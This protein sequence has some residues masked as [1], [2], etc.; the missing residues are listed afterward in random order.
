MDRVHP[1]WK[2]IAYV[3]AISIAIGMILP[4]LWMVSTSLK[5]NNQIFMIPPQWIPRPAHWENYKKV[6]ELLNFGRYY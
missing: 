1:V 6:F 4:F 2:T 3:I 5:D